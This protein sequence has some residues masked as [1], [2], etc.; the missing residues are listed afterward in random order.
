MRARDDALAGATLLATIDGPR[1]KRPDAM[2]QAASSTAGQFP[3]VISPLFHVGL[4]KEPNHDLEYKCQTEILLMAS[5]VQDDQ[6]DNI[7]FFIYKKCTNI[8]KK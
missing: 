8:C 1:N 6:L 5:A 4:L 7:Y 2:I 3:M